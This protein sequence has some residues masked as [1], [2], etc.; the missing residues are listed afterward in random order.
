MNRLLLHPNKMTI[1]V[2]SSSDCLQIITFFSCKVNVRFWNSS[3]KNTFRSS[4]I[5][6]NPISPLSKQRIKFH[7]NDAFVMYCPFYK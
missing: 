3:L 6:H 5:L 4:V 2:F 7:Y 1:A